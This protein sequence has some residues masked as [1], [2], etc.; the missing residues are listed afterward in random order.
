MPAFDPPAPDTSECR[1]DKF[2]LY[3]TAVTGDVSFGQTTLNT[4]REVDRGQELA[5]T[6]GTQR[7]EDFL[8]LSLLNPMGHTLPAKLM[9]LCTQPHLT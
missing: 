4:L 5:A 7:T 9:H 2:C 3:D 6:T 1:G 8:I